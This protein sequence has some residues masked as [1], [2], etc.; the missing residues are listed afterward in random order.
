MALTI[1]QERLRQLR[2]ILIDKG[3]QLA[4]AGDEEGMSELVD[5]AKL[6]GVSS[7]WLVTLQGAA[8]SHRGDIPGADPD[9]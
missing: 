1:A 5:Q 3:F 9:S 7:D 4:L 8:L 6:A 2:N